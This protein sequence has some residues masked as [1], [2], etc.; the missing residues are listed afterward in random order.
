MQD[1]AGTA[2]LL[3]ELRLEHRD[4]DTA[5]NQLATAIGRDELQL[6]R[7]KKRKLLLKD[8]IARLESKLIPDLD[9]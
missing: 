4:L 3:A 5:I 1:H 6:T 2:Q 7:L 8:H 9:A